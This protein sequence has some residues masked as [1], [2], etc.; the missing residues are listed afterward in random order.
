M[1]ETPI[2]AAA[3]AAGL[4]EI[5]G[6]PPFAAY[7]RD[8]V[9]LSAFIRAYARARAA[10][11]NRRR[12]LGFLW[13]LLDPVLTMTVYWVLF[14]VLL[15]ARAIVPN[16]LGFL[17]VGVFTYALIRRSLQA[18]ARSISGSQGFIRSL[19][20]PASVFPATAVLQQLRTFLA[21]VPVL[22]AVLIATGER[23]T[24]SWLLFPVAIVVTL[25]FAFGGALLLA[26]WV[27]G[28]PDLA[29]AL[30]L[31]LRLWGLLSGVMIPVGD[32]LGKMG[33]PD[34]AVSIA[35]INPPAVF[36]SLARGTLLNGEP[37]PGL[38]LWAIGVAWTLLAFIAG[39]VVFWRGEGQYARD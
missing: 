8:T 30:P 39:S 18:G 2:A 28:I 17:A 14:G 21:S 5:G 12:R 6:H 20:M 22:L 37:L 34:W 23:P 29:G 4:R 31:S 13:N 36:L 32:R 35:D 38:S 24:W 9:R 15:Q 11:G 16:Y 33:A 27:H 25:P 1:A 26:R 19:P 10:S 3:A 7:V